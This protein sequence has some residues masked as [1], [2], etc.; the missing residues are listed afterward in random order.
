MSNQHN[1]RERLTAK[2]FQNIMGFKRSRALS[3]YRQ[4]KQAKKR[5]AELKG[6]RRADSI[7]A[8]TTYVFVDDLA[9]YSGLSREVIKAGL[10]D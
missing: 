8:T 2:D 6:A 10:V 4:I 1:P 7:E 9:E 3:Y 5:R